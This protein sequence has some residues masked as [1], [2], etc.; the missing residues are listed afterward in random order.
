[1]LFEFTSS[2]HDS[3]L[4]KEYWKTIDFQT[5]HRIKAYRERRKNKGFNLM[6]GSLY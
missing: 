1:M 2:I 4:P 6:N 5:F 3:E